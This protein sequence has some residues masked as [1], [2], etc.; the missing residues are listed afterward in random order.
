[1][2][3]GWACTARPISRRWRS[4]TR[5]CSPTTSPT[6]RP[7]GARRRSDD[8]YDHVLSDDEKR[9]L[10]RIARAT[11]REFLAVGRIPPGAPHKQTLL[12]P[13]GVFVTLTEGDD[14]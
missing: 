6:G 12:E 13:A 9:E 14:L 7:A 11:L 5:R 8:V 2:R 4:I 1:M 3:R 10:L